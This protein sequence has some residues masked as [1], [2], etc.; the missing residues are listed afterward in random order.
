MKK[1]CIYLNQIEL[2]DQIEDKINKYIPIKT[3]ESISYFKTRCNKN[4]NMND[5]YFFKVD[6]NQINYSCKQRKISDNFKRNFEIKKNDINLTK[7][8]KIFDLK[9]S[10]KEDLNSKRNI[11]QK[12]INKNNEEKK[13][14]TIINNDINPDIF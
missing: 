9:N 11:N 6:E 4:I 12:R 2:S 3:E 13:T 1:R 14:L 5:Y 8:K 10:K 7:R